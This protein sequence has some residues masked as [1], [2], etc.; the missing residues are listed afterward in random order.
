MLESHRFAKLQRSELGPW[1]AAGAARLIQRAERLVQTFSR[2]L[3]GA[4]V[5]PDAHRDLEIDV[6]LHR[7]GRIHVNRLHEPARLVGANWQEC[8]IDCAERAA[9]LVKETSVARVACEV[10]PAISG[11]EQESAPQ[12][13]I[14]IERAAGGEMLR[15]RQRDGHWRL[16]AGLPPIEFLDASDARRA[17]R[18]RGA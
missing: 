8:Q 3:E 9:N 13:A 16:R 17:H 14:A 12:G 2:E 11:R 6:R 15:R 7:L 4:K 1:H 5:H 18:C 10:D